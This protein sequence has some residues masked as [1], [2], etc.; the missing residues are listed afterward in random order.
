VGAATSSISKVSPSRRGKPK[1]KVDTL[2]HFEAFCK[3]FIVLD[4]GKPF[5]LE[6]FQKVILA[7]YFAGVTETLVLLPK[8]NGKTTLLAALAL[9]HLIYTKDAECYIAASVKRQAGIMYRQVCRFVE[10]KGPDGR[11]LPQSAA[12]QKRVELKKGYK[13]IRSKRDSGF[14]EVISGDVDTGDGVNPTLALVDELHRHKDDGALYGVLLDGLTEE[15]GGQ[16]ITIST[17]GQTMKSA[18]GRIRRK[19]LKLGAKRRGC[20]V[21]VRSP[22]GD[23]EMHEWSLR[24]EDDREDLELVKQANPLTAMTIQKLRSRK[25]SPSMKPSQ[26]ARFAC[27]VWVKGEDAAISSVDW[28]R[29]GVDG[30]VLKE[31]AEVYLSIDLGWKWDCTA[32][33]VGEPFGREELEIDGEEFWRWSKVRFGA[34]EILHPPRNGESLAFDDVIN[35][36]VKFRDEDKLKVLG[37]VM[38]PNADGQRVAQELERLG[39]EV[40][41]HSQDARMMAD[42]S[43]GFAEAVGHRKVEQ[44]K[45]EEFTDQVLAGIAK[46]AGG[47]K[48]RFAA[49]SQNRGQRKKGVQEKE[50]VEYVDAGTAAVMLH[51]IAT[52]PKP[53]EEDEFDAFDYRMEF[54]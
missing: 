42:S 28:E 53:L 13:E 26:W 47:E 49:P 33:D 39:F 27:G 52:S 46:P 12:L 45:D 1:L 50:D 19:A 43:M 9:Y 18:L 2:E 29:S 41:E 35:A 11:L 40:I 32:V 4:N 20:Y 6:P 48:W 22:N 8:K 38:D 36:A 14:I 10:R 30:L 51:R 25:E 21:H 44:P 3:K 16:L 24:D 31:G 23:F 34:P 54:V 37:V 17:A 7:G 5:E 15:R